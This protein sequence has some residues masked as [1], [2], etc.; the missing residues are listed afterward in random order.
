MAEWIKVRQLK[1]EVVLVERVKWCS[2]YICR[3]KGLMFRHKLGEDEGLLLVD[4]A[5]SRWGA[6]IH[7]WFVFMPLGVI[8]L[9][10]QRKVVDIKVARPWRV[11]L[12]AQ[13]A[14]YILETSP[15]YL[16]KV[17]VG[18]RLEFVDA[19]MV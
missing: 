10:C 1:T 9:D 15:A 12:P 16:E 2:S 11:Y 3:L 6:S 19:Q 5:E 13:A 18:D 4:A 14:R 7:M 17:Q 8:W